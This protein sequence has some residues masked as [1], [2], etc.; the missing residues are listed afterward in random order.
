M[1]GIVCIT[2]RLFVCVQG[3]A[4]DGGVEGAAGTAMKLSF[5]VCTPGDGRTDGDQR[6]EFAK[7]FLAYQGGQRNGT[8]IWPVFPGT[9]GR[10][11]D[12]SICQE[13]SHIK[14]GRGTEPGY[15]QYFRGR[16]DGDTKLQYTHVGNL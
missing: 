7:N 13:I 4:G 12:I 15:G 6:S 8:G 5:K 3:A 16:T 14:G 9:D 1:V 11:S 10:R 2:M